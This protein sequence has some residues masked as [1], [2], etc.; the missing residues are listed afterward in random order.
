MYSGT[1]TIAYNLFQDSGDTTIWGDGS[2]VTK[3][4]NYTL[5]LGGSETLP[6]Y[7]NVPGGQNV[8]AGTYTDGVS[9]TVTLY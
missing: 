7:G 8:R 1:N 2:G 3:T 6:I 5:P 4:E 9:V